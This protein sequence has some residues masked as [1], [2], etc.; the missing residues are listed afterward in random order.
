MA[1]LEFWQVSGA[2][3]IYSGSSTKFSDSG[4]GQHLSPY[5]AAKSLNTQLLVDFSKWYSLPYV[6]VYFHNVYGGREL[7]DGKYSTVIGKYKSLVEQGQSHLPVTR[8]GDQVRNFTH[9]KDILHGI[10]LATK[11][12]D[13]DGYVIG[14]DEAF[15]ILDVCKLFGCKPRFQPGSLA[16]RM[17]GDLRS[18]KIKKLGWRQQNKLTEHIQNFLCEVHLKSNI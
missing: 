8:P 9:I 17:S 10:L 12:G 14:A 4:A 11:S 6:I 18:D 5:T 3:L 1:L 15:S 2:K 13:G 16:N 7:R